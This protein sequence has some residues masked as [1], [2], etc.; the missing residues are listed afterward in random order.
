M[1]WQFFRSDDGRPRTSDEWLGRFRNFWNF[2]EGFHAALYLH[3]QAT[4]KKIRESLKNTEFSA[5][6]SSRF[7][8]FQLV[9]NFCTEPVFIFYSGLTWLYPLLRWKGANLIFCIILIYLKI[10]KVNKTFF[11]DVNWRLFLQIT[12]PGPGGAYALIFISIHVLIYLMSQGVII[13]S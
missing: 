6:G 5:D 7:P 2:G 1:R 10:S 8:S 9:M 11:K 3:P 12:Q 4:L 13:K